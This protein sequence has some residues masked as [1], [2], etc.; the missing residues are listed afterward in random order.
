[1]S[2]LTKIFIVLLAVASVAFAMSTV[3]FVAQTNNWRKLAE[4]YYAARNIAETKMVNQSAAQ[5]AEKA[6]WLDARR[7]SLREGGALK[8]QLQEAQQNVAKANAELAQLRAEKSSTDALAR[9]LTGQLDLA[10]VGRDNEQKQR[11]SF[12]ERNIEL[13]TRNIDLNK[14]VNEL[15]AQVQ[16]LVEQQRQFTQQINILREEN[17]KLAAISRRAATGAFE[18]ATA[19]GVTPLEPVAGTPIRGRILEVDGKLATISV[20]SADGVQAN[21]TFVIYRGANY[22][23]D[24]RVTDVEPHRAAGTIVHAQGTPR[25]DDLVADEVRFGMA[26]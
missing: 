15:T 5:A 19:D 1:M 18:A 2:P 4:D 25:V 20:G 23:G 10:S 12:Q 8:A 7:E 3:S 13:E 21:M 9:N 17:D 26:G 6:N 22:I 24:L 11:Q 14:R 16:V